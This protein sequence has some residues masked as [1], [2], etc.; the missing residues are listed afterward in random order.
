MMVTDTPPPPPLPR[1][2]D[3]NPAVWC[4]WCKVEMRPGT[5]PATHGI[6]PGCHKKLEDQIEARARTKETNHE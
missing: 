5:L 4:G 3:A 2:S 1:D 6:C